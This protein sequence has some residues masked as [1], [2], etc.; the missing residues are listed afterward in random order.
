MEFVP[1]YISQKKFSETL[2]IRLEFQG[3]ESQ[4]FVSHLG[5]TS[6]MPATDDTQGYMM[7][8]RPKKAY[9]V[10][11]KELDFDNSDLLNSNKNDEKVLDDFFNYNNFDNRRDTSM[12]V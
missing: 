1:S 10:S 4:A 11:Q 3:Y 12:T 9:W 5:Q 8:R 6:A 2:K 7:L